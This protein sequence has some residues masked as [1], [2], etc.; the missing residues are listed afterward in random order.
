MTVFLPVRVKSLNQDNAFFTLCGTE[1]ICM[2]SK[3]LLDGEV[4]SGYATNWCGAK[5]VRPDG[6]EKLF[7]CQ[8]DTGLASG[9]LVLC[10]EVKHRSGSY[11]MFGCH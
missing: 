10:P 11:T 5:Y 6:I 1:F 4:C 2:N 9:A 3:P 8:Y 7:V